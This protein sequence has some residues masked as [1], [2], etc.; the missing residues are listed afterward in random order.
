MDY[1]YKIYP[2]L[3]DSYLRYL[4]NGDFKEDEVA[5]KELI[6]RINRVEIFPLP[7]PIL[8]GKELQRL[9]SDFARKKEEALKYPEEVIIEGK[10]V[11]TNLIREL[12]GRVKGSLFEVYLESNLET[13]FGNVLLYGYADY[14]KHN[15]IIDLKYVQSYD[16]GKYYNYTQRLVYPYCLSNLHIEYFEYLATDLRSIYPET[17][18]FEKEMHTNVLRGIVESF[19]GFLNDHRELIT[20]KKIFGGENEKERVP[21]CLV[22]L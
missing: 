10:S 7:Q 11:R 13:K 18:V 14:V 17:Y 19:I 15:M 9:V 5:K 20:D 2:S 6:D 1:N 22:N 12:A 16:I 3:L 4:N 8:I 21:N